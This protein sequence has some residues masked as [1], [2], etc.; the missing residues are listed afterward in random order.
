MSFRCPYCNKPLDI[1][2]DRDVLS[3]AEASPSGVTAVVVNHGDHAVVVYVDSEG[4]IRS[5]EAAVLPSPRAGVLNRIKEIPIP[6]SSPPDIRVLKRDGWRF[7][8]L[9]DGKR[10]LRAISELLNIDIRKI[11]LLAESLRA[12]GYLKEIKLK[13]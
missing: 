4:N 11:R 10:D 7:L 5:L 9:C 12:R 3:R 6:H 1:S 2:I 13:I 8:A